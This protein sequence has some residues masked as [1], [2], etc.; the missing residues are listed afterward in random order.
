MSHLLEINRNSEMSLVNKTD[1]ATASV[2]LA[3]NNLLNDCSSI[4]TVCLDNTLNENNVKIKRFPPHTS[5]IAI[6]FVVNLVNYIDRFS[7][8][9]NF[10]FD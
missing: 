10:N 8:A 1:P 5:T 2:S 9:G 6:L 7:I 4:C 3:N